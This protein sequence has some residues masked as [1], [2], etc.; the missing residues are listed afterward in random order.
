MSV[1]VWTK[2]FPLTKAGRRRRRLNRNLCLVSSKVVLFPWVRYIKATKSDDDVLAS[3][4]ERDK[5]GLRARDDALRPIHIFRNINS[6]TLKSSK[7]TRKRD[8]LRR[9]G[10]EK[11]ERRRAS[12]TKAFTHFFAKEEEDAFVFPVEL[13]RVDHRTKTKTKRSKRRPI[14]AHLNGSCSVGVMTKPFVVSFEDDMAMTRASKGGQY[15]QSVAVEQMP[16]RVTK[17][18]RF[19]LP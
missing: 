4:R 15:F 1:F 17:E 8:R 14:D 12:T 11:S 2:T 3:S 6:M 16:I 19:S 18:R 10:R 9:L 5:A 13:R 7:K